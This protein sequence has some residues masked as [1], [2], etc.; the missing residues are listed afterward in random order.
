M[1]CLYGVVATFVNLCNA[2]DKQE[3]I[4]E[5]L[6]LAKFAKQHVPEAHDMDDQ[7]F[8]D[9]RIKVLAEEG[10]A[11]ALSVLSKTDS[12]NSRELISRYRCVSSF[13]CPSEV[14]PSCC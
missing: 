3:V 10:A 7:D 2:Y 5:M 14:E 12:H 4:P 13:C 8:V 6:E 9:K 1:N 11:G